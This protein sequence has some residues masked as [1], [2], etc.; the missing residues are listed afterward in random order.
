MVRGSIRGKTAL[1]TGSARRI[2]RCI[3]LALAD[4]GANIVAHYNTSPAEAEELA[5][6]LAGRGVDAWTVQADFDRRDEIDLLIDRAVERAGPVDILV[7]NAS[8]F[9][10]DNLENVTFESVVENLQVNAWAP[11]VLSRAFAK[12]M[13]RGRIVNLLDSR[14]SGYDWSHA[15]YI[16]SKHVLAVMTRMTALEF[17]PDI[18][19]NAVAPGLILPPPGKDESYIERLAGTVPLKRH[20]EPEDVADAVLYLVKSDF[21]TGEVIYVDGGRHLKEYTNG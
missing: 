6:E 13:G 3:A 21:V 7:N 8:I 17:A 20:G 19:V 11:F 9:P 1:I 4:E 18:T 14:V 15:A 12:R 16:W 10:S 5:G 2:G